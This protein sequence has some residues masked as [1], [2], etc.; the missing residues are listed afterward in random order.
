MLDL[1]AAHPFV[2]VH[3]HRDLIGF[4][5]FLMREII[6]YSDQSIPNFKML[7][8]QPHAEA[9]KIFIDFPAYLDL[10]SPE[11][12]FS[13]YSKLSPFLHTFVPLGYII[14][15]RLHL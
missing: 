1:I 13:F 9:L 12:C 3:P 7:V 4:P 10:R 8:F 14:F 2:L 11:N 15:L 5:A 6:D